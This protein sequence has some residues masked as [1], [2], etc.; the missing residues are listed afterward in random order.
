MLLGE[1][2][3][4]NT[5]TDSGIC[6]S[7]KAQMEATIFTDHFAL[8]IHTFFLLYAAWHA[9]V[10]LFQYADCVLWG[11]GM[12]SERKEGIR[13]GMDADSVGVN[14]LDEALFDF[15]YDLAHDNLGE[16]E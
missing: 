12:V 10:Y 7:G 6:A 5:T 3:R 13:T 16:E 8:C 9:G 1:S 15:V 11:T 14:D 2:A 4:S